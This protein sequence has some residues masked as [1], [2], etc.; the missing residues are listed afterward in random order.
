MML[1]H[2]SKFFLQH[3][4]FCRMCNRSLYIIFLFKLKWPKNKIFQD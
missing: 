3:A 1:S 4:L 2:L